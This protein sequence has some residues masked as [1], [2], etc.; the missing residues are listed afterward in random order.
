MRGKPIRAHQVAYAI[1][2]NG[3]VLPPSELAIH[4]A[5]ENKAC[6][7]PAHLVLLSFGDHVREHARRRKHDTLL[8][9]VLKEALNVTD[10]GR[11]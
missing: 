5:C 9:Q 3:G 4:H 1:A 8:P 2:K 6:C 7:N 11:K 10:D